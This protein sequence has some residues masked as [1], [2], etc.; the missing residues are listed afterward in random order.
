VQH[1]LQLLLLINQSV[2]SGSV[3]NSVYGLAS[4][5]GNSNNVSDT[6]DDGDDSD[7]NTQMIKRKQ[8]LIKV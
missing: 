8:T 6:S 3:L 2:D 1:I 5:P 4:S 7:G